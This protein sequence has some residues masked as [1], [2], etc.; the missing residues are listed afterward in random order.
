M[1]VVRKSDDRGHADHG[2]LKSWHTFSFADYYDPAHMAF[3]VLRVINEDFIDPDQ[4]FGTHPH[5]DM[6][7]V[8]YVIE[9]SLK[10]RDTLGNSST[11]SPGEIQ[12]M[13]AGTGIQHSEFNGSK[14][15]TTHL[16][17]IWLMPKAQGL[18]PGYEQKN[19][20]SLMSTTGLHKV[21]SGKPD[22][23]IVGINQDVDIYVGKYENSGGE[24]KLQQGRY[25]WLQ[26]VRGGV[27]LFTEGISLKAGDGLAIGDEKG[28]SF[29]A[30]GPTEFLFFDLP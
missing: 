11:I 30:E 27:T 2:W 7:I 20:S 4:G 9:G 19:L 18:K 17:Q 22:S 28:F 5:K 24:I 23:S 3:R 26:V 12:R 29:R 25:G 15:E 21:V 16:L 1:F 8:T 10:H 13:S 14:D 6:E